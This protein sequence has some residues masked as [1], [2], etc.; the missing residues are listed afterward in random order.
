MRAHLI[1]CD[2]AEVV[3]GRLYLLG[4]CW[5]I[6]GPHPVNFGV[7]VEVWVPWDAMNAKHSWRLELL[8]IDGK[9]AQWLANGTL[10]G[11]RIE[12]NFEATRGPG[13]R[14]GSDAPVALAVNA[15][16][17][18]LP[19]GDYEMR[20]WI[21]GKTESSWRAVFNIRSEKPVSVPPGTPGP[22]GR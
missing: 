5:T 18:P 21:D 20:L 10:I 7:A 4:G 17:V 16:G 15:G 8:D 14:R 3:N 1:L 2:H 22:G 9:A 6:S 19:P 13:L 11:F 12:G